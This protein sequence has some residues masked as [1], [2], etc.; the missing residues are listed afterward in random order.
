MKGAYITEHPEA[1][2]M[3]QYSDHVVAF[4]DILGF[5]KLVDDPK[6]NGVFLER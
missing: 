4:L 5:S 6:L 2:N 3:Y 1:E